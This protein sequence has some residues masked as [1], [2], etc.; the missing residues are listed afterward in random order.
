MVSGTALHDPVTAPARPAGKPP[1]RRARPR[2]GPTGAL[3]VPAVLLLLYFVALPIAGMLVQSL[4]GAEGG[5]TLRNY[6]DFVT[7]ERLMRATLNTVVVSVAT[8]AGSVLIATPLAFGVARTNMWGKGLVRFAVLVC[9]AS[10]P[11][12]MTL[13]YI[14]IA[15]PNAG[16]L[17][18][19]LRSLFGLDTTEGPVN[20]FSLGGFVLL[21][22]PHTVALVF[23]MMLPAFGTMDA[24]LEEA[25]RIAGAGPLQTV[26]RISLPTMR[27]A[28]MAGGL[29]TFSHALAMYATPQILGIDVLTVSMR[30]SILIDGD[31]GQAA[32]IAAVSAV[33]SMT[34]LYFYRRSVSAG[35]RYQTITGKGLRLGAL[36]LR[37]GRHLLGGAGLLYAV[38]GALMPY[39]L[40]IAISFMKVPADGLAAANLTLGHYTTI[41]GD[42]TVRL[43]IY[44][45]LLLGVGAA[46]VIAVLG[47]LLAY[48]VTKTEAR[49]RAVVDYLTVLPLGIAGTAF[50][51]GVI[52]TNLETP[53]RS[54][55]LYASVWILLVAYIGRYIPFGMRTAQ[56]A[57]LQVS[58]ELGEASRVSGAGQVRTLWHI[59]LPLVRA[60]V[61]Y[62]WILG[63][64]QAFAEVSASAIL[65]GPTTQVTAVSLIGL[66]QGT[67]GLQRASALGVLMFVLTLALVVLAQRLGG[68]SIVPRN[69]GSPS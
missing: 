57:L 64:V 23:V 2:L 51:V 59:A 6:A 34:V 20:V 17:N 22:L 67:D 30:R 39:S 31:F 13:A 32:T 18:V 65:S 42:H 43:A 36:D 56:V 53:L 21:A 54:L 61:S 58:R 33:L 37:R 25:S 4:R 5:F 28:M 46:T 49:G 19:L 3:F 8:G 60:G 10:P 29:L 41:L 69:P 63:F 50:A 9:F 38:L 15:G 40:M 7:S 1:G 24:S 55:G 48:L 44:N 27:A 52:V 14:F 26:W 16:Y 62:A 35:L 12:L 66:W 47:F 68:Q 11:F 45:S